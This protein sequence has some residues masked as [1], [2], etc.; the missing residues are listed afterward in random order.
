VVRKYTR[1]VLLKEVCSFLNQNV[2]NDERLVIDDEGS[3]WDGGSG[4]S[5]DT[6]L[7]YLRGKRVSLQEAIEKADWLL[8]LWVS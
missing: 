2:K 5:E 3:I 4:I 8:E 7:L 1:R 6:L